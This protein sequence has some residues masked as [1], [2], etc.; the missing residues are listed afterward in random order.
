MTFHKRLI[1]IILISFSFLDANPASPQLSNILKGLQKSIGSGSNLT[2]N[3]IGNGLKEALT[4][5]IQKAVGAV[6]NLDGY[7]KNPNIKIPLPSAVKKV[8]TILRGVG[9]GS[10]IDAF[11]LSMNRA[12]EKA[13]PEATSIFLE[14]IKQMSFSDARKILEGSDNEATLYLK[15]KTFEKLGRTFKPIVNESM[16]GIGVTQQYQDINTKL[17]GIP[18]MKPLS[19][20]LDQYV[21]EGALDGLFYMLAEEE[22]KIR[23]DPAARVNDILKKVFGSQS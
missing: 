15:D 18:F 14:A 17:S 21:T 19:F 23:S 11:E 4:I 12:A 9:Y 3:E 16:S 10:K 1:F 5:G 2:E 7:Y 8:E 6:S 13:A 22:R 20:D